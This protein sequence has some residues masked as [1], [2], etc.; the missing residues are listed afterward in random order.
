MRNV[1]NLR[2]PLRRKTLLQRTFLVNYASPDESRKI[3]FK[4][5][6]CRNNLCF[7]AFSNA[8]A[9]VSAVAPEAQHALRAAASSAGDIRDWTLVRYGPEALPLV[10]LAA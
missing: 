5:M 3:A 4:A 1:R 6:D 7:S 2:D 9:A 8:L 10:D